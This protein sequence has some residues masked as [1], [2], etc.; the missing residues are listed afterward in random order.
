MSKIGFLQNLFDTPV[1]FIQPITCS[2]ISLPTPIAPASLA[3]LIDSPSAA[4][5]LRSKPRPFWSSTPPVPLEVFPPCLIFVEELHNCVDTIKTM[6]KVYVSTHKTLNPKLTVTFDK[7]TK[8]PNLRAASEFAV[9]HAAGQLA[10]E[11]VL[12]M[13]IPLSKT[14]AKENQAFRAISTAPPPPARSLR[15]VLGERQW[16]VIRIVQLIL[17]LVCIFGCIFGLIHDLSK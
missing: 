7:P 17:V 5:W 16:V 8:Y 1:F 6:T 2:S 15:E 14:E 3:K 9:G 12:G 11:L 10:A 4:F 13:F